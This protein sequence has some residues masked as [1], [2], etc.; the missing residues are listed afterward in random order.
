[1]LGRRRMVVVVVVEW[2]GLGVRTRRADERG[3]GR[4]DTVVPGVLERRRRGRETRAARGPGRGV[5]G[6]HGT[7]LRAGCSASGAREKK[8][9]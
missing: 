2:H 1:M 5:R 3:S 6:G 9:D 7:L 4:D 8:L